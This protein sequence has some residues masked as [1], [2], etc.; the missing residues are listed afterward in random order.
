MGNIGAWEI[1][2]IILVVLLIFGPKQLPKIGRSLGRGMREFKETVTDTGREIKEATAVTPSE[3]KAA[4]N[5]LAPSPP[6]PA[7]EPQASAPPPPAAATAPPP[8]PPVEEP[9]A[10]VVAEE[11]VEPEPGPA[12]ERATSA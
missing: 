3:F 5:P 7:A 1:A 4:L 12:P 9:A 11:I 8:A 10:V 6:K 2:L